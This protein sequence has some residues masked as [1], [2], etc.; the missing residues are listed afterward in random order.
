M[1]CIT[2]VIA[3]LI[4][5][6]KS[7]IGTVYLS[8]KRSGQFDLQRLSA[9]ELALFADLGRRESIIKLAFFRKC[10]GTNILHRKL[11]NWSNSYDKKLSEVFFPNAN[12][13]QYWKYIFTVKNISNMTLY[14][15]ILI[16]ETRSARARADWLLTLYNAI[17]RIA[18]NLLETK[19]K[20][21]IESH[22]FYHIICD[23]FSWGSS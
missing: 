23:R 12:S 19:E 1:C 6:L 14:Q 15:S 8:R 4:T 5:V 2:Q 9:L 22:S 20:I 13:L 7:L 16:T 10:H 11:G 21:K 18:R 17:L 3:Y